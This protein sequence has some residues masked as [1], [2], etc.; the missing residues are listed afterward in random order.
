M[1]SRT[2]V[3]SNEPTVIFLPRKIPTDILALVVLRVTIEITGWLAIAHV[4][5][6]I[7]SLQITTMGHNLVAPGIRWDKDNSKAYPLAPGHTGFQGTVGER[8]SNAFGPW[9]HPPPPPIQAPPRSPP[10]PPSEHPADGF[11]P[12]RWN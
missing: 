4:I 3:P 7:M 2:P 1:N 12:H 5:S 8:T 6:R 10:P 11:D 9:S